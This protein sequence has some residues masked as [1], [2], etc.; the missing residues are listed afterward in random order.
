MAE[1]PKGIVKVGRYNITDLNETKGFTPIVVMT[2]SHGGEWTL[3][4]YHLRDENGYIMENIWQFSKIYETIPAMPGKNHKGPVYWLYNS[5]RHFD[6]GTILPTYWRW[7]QTGFSHNSAVRYP[8]GYYHRNKCMFAILS[9]D[10]QTPLDYIESRKKIYV[11]VYC[12]LVEQ[13][14]AFQ[15][16]KQ[17]LENGENLLILEVDGPHSESLDYYKQKYNVNDNFIVNNTVV[18]NRENLAIL[19]ND[20]KHPFGHGYCLS[21][22]LLGLH[23]LIH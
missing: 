1:Q 2:K 13:Q 3:S 20:P 21:M 7:R 5:E 22:S 12:R 11:P 6:N 19:L 9:K 18:A 17:R 15:R 14:S 4:P 16:L 10:D 8:V 23:D